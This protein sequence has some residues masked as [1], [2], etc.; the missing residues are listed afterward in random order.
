ML[1]R[2]DRLVEFTIGAI[3]IALVIT[4]FA[5][6][7]ARYVFGHSFVWVLEVD[8]LL[9]VWLTLLSGYVGVR[10]VGGRRVAGGDGRRGQWRRQRRDGRHVLRLEPARADRDVREPAGRHGADA[11]GDR[12]R[13][14]RAAAR[15]VL[16]LQ[17][18][19]PFWLL[20]GAFLGCLA[21]GVPVFF[22][23]CLASLSFILAL[24]CRVPLHGLAFP[25]LYVGV[26][27]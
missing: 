24:G 11:G 2:L 25:L 13:A 16:V 21:M 18:L 15:Q 7:V 10:A 12:G 19:L 14:G 1:G 22:A 23:L 9:M 5:Q 26:W 3:A 17:Q 8:V 20:M 4:A 6:V 27:F